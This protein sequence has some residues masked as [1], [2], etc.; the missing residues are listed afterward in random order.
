MVAFLFDVRASL[1]RGKDRSWS[2]A[3]NQP[4]PQGLFK[5]AADRERGWPPLSHETEQFSRP[6]PRVA[7]RGE[8]DLTHTLNVNFSSNYP[9]LGDSD[10]LP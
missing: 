7:S 5:M 10:N 8:K 4:R 3:T 1:C 9:T 6:I 2:E